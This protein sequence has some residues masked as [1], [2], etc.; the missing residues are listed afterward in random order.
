MCVNIGRIV[1]LAPTETT[2]ES[3]GFMIAKAELANSPDPLLRPY[4]ATVH[5]SGL[6]L[7]AQATAH[8]MV[9]GLDASPLSVFLGEI[10]HVRGALAVAEPIAKMDLTAQI[11]DLIR[12]GDLE[13]A[14][15]LHELSGDI[16]LSQP[17][18]YKVTRAGHGVTKFFRRQRS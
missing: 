2:M 9:L 6:G 16:G 15:L 11:G 1:A 17:F 12:A 10:E 5:T 13:T 7:G 8:L 18:A 4:A 3:Y 14:E